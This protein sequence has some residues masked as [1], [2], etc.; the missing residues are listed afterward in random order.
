M[1]LHSP[2]KIWLVLHRYFTVSAGAHH[3]LFPGGDQM[4]NGCFLKGCSEQE[5]SEQEL[6]HFESGGSG[7]YKPFLIRLQLPK[8]LQDIGSGKREAFYF[9]AF[10]VWSGCLYIKIFLWTN[11]GQGVSGFATC[12]KICT[13]ETFLLILQLRWCQMLF[14]LIDFKNETSRRQFLEKFGA[15]SSRGKCD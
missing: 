4:S 1:Q 13:A 15:R 10:L 11:R 6:L 2:S 12:P 7:F 8:L 3:D 9:L 5:C 14:I